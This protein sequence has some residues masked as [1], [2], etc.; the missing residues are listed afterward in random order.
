MDWSSIS[1]IVAGVCFLGMLLFW[2]LAAAQKS[3]GKLAGRPSY[4]LFAWLAFVCCLFF[5]FLAFA[6]LEINVIQ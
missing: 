3:A 6:T 4:A 2:G 5:V 1:I